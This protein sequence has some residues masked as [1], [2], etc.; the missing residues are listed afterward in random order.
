M[1]GIFQTES[2]TPAIPNKINVPQCLWRSLSL[3]CP[4]FYIKTTFSQMLSS[5]EGEK[6]KGFVVLTAI[7]TETISVILKGSE[8]DTVTI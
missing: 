1:L 8:D 2:K 5:V 4:A 7:I 6:N 3:S